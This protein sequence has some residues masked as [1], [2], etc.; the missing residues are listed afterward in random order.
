MLRSVFAVLLLTAGSCAAGDGLPPS[1]VGKWDQT[2][3]GCADP[4]S[5]NGV[6]ITPHRVQFYEAGGDVRSVKRLSSGT[7]E[8][9]ADWADVNVEGPDGLPVESVMTIRLAPSSAGSSL[10]IEMRDAAWTLVPCGD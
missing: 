5:L 4:E 6:S 7:V 10:T 9:S 2:V 8:V 3:A 1:V